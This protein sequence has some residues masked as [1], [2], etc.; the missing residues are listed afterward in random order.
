[1]VGGTVVV[2]ELTGGGEGGVV[3]VVVVVGSVPLLPPPTAI[4]VV[5]PGCG[6]Q[7]GGGWDW[8]GTF[9]AVGTTVGVDGV[10]VLGTW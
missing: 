8:D 9:P 6:C 4:G 3:D 7:P 2:V 10:D 5:E 1:M